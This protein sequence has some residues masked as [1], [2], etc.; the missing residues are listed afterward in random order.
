MLRGDGLALLC[1]IMW[2]VITPAMGGGVSGT[3]PDGP[4]RVLG[5]VA[6]TASAGLVAPRTAAE[7]VLAAVRALRGRLE[8]SGAA[9]DAASWPAFEGVEAASVVL[10]RGGEI[11]GEATAASFGAAAARAVEIATRLTDR[12]G[13]ALDAER[14][15]ALRR[16]RVI[17]V[18]LAGRLVPLDER[19][20]YVAPGDPLQLPRPSVNPGLEGIAA[21]RG[22]SEAF[23]TPGAM[24]RAGMDPAEAL[25][26]VLADVTGDPAAAARPVAEAFGDGVTVYRFEV[27]HAAEMSAGG[28]ARLL[29][30]GG[31]VVRASA[32]QSAAGIGALAVS[33]AEHLAGRVWPGV[34]PFGLMGTLDPLTGR[35]ASTAAPAFEQ[36]LAAV[37]FAR[38][39]EVAGSGVADGAGSGDRFRGVAL[40]LLEELAVVGSGEV[41]AAADPMSAAM[42]LYAAVLIGSERRDAAGGSGAWNTRDTARMLEACEEVVL[43]AYAGGGFAEGV[44]EGGRGLVALGLIASGEVAAGDA[45]IRAAFRDVPVARLAGQMP[46]LVW[47]ERAL[48][49]ARRAASAGAEITVPSAVVLEQARTLVLGFQLRDADLEPRDRDLAGGIVLATGDGLPFPTSASLRPIAGLGAM[50]AERS[51]TLPGTPRFAEMLSRQTEMCRFVAQLSATAAAGHMYRRPGRSI[52]GVRASLWE[53]SM[54]NDACSLAVIALCEVLVATESD[55]SGG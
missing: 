53:Q 49:D 25:S 4:G 17:E 42:T 8:A 30:R 50:L 36:A 23:V 2:C 47:A 28:P 20:F 16:S 37:A 19:G 14:V 27:A 44:P 48:A 13:D 31:E 41:G 39:A 45:A 26:V 12:Q 40:G 51:L 10:R 46:Y 54:P 33:I 11:A 18:E 52:H 3:L 55:A 21:R 43:G 5:V 38:L 15:A 29:H 22:A 35:H 34:E 9:V 24:L 32:V 6:G 7:R 1:G